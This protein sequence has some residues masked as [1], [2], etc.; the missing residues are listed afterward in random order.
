ME[1]CNGK[2]MLALL[3]GAT[4]GAG[5]GIL[6]A[7]YKGSKTRRKIKRSVTDTSQNVSEFVKDAKDAIR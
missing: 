7:P 1:R 6:F 3:T 5:L 2:L 4:I